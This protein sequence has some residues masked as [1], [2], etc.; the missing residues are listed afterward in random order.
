MRVRDSGTG[1]E[2]QAMFF[3]RLTRAAAFLLLALNVSGAVASAEG[4]V[5]VNGEDATAA[6]AEEG[7]SADG[8]SLAVTLPASIKRGFYLTKL[9]YFPNQALTACAPGYHMGS[10]WELLA[11]STMNY[12]YNHPL[13]TTKADSGRGAPSYWYG[14]VRTGTDAAAVNTAGMGNCLNWT[15][16]SNSDYGV[17]VRLTRDWSTPLGPLGPWQAT[18]FTCATISPVWCVSNKR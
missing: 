7:V 16:V 17:A 2:N 6:L 18:S 8:R 1:R 10:I 9:T 14:W 3:R 15:S 12:H 4:P 13:A 5:S 11:V